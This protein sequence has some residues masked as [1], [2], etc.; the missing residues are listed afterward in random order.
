ML[1]SIKLKL[2]TFRVPPI[3]N[4]NLKA[5]VIPLAIVFKSASMHLK[6]SQRTSGV[7]GCA[8]DAHF[9]N[10][11]YMVHHSAVGSLIV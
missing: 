11:L 7:S 10:A 9:V 4:L 3:T 2:Q 8:I 1:V 6:E 5:A